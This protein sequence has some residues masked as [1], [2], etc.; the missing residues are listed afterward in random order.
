MQPTASSAPAARRPT[1]IAPAEW[2]RSQ[3]SVAPRSRRGGLER[4]QVGDR[5]AA[6][7]DVR[8]DDDVARPARERRRVGLAVELAQR[9]AA[10]GRD[11]LEHV[12]VGGEVAAVGDERAAARHRRATSL[13]RLTVV[14]S[15]TST[16]PGSAPISGA[17]ASPVRSGASIQSGQPPTSRSP[18]SSAAAASRARVATGSRPSELPSR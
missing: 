12:A 7:A 14:E 4:R 16:S 6:V 5:A 17:S 1:G 9:D 13:N 3:I 10:L 15:Q 18:H 11:P 2:L 8:E